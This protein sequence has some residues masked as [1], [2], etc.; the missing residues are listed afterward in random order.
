MLN[1]SMM[2]CLQTHL[3]LTFLTKLSVTMLSPRPDPD[4]SL[5]TLVTVSTM[6]S[7]PSPFLLV[8]VLVTF[9]TFLTPGT[10]ADILTVSVSCL[11][12]PRTETVPSP[13]CIC[14]V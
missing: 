2:S 11:Q 9:L 5:V 3:P 7:P 8:V 12:R 4:V 10:A 13:L 14:S 6:V 1:D